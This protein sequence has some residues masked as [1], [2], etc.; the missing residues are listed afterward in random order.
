MHDEGATRGPGAPDGDA[1]YLGRFAVFAVHERG[2]LGD[3][4]RAHDLRHGRTVRLRHAP[5]PRDGEQAAQAGQLRERLA[6]EWRVAGIFAG[7]HPQ[8]VQVY[9]LEVTPEG[10]Q[11]LVTEDVEGGTLRERLTEAGLPLAAAFTVAADVAAALAAAHARGVVHRNLKPANIYLTAAGRAK[12]AD[13]S[14]AQIG[15]D[16]PAGWTHPYT[17]LY[18]SPEQE[19][20]R[21][22][23]GPAS[24]QYALGLV[25]F[26]MLTGAK[27]KRIEP[28]RA[29]QLLEAFPGDV[30]YLVTRMLATEPIDRFRSLD[31]VAEEIATLRRVYTATPAPPAP[32]T[33]QAFPGVVANV[34][35]I[36]EPVPARPD[37]VSPPPF[38]PAT[39]APAPTGSDVG[40]TGAPAPAGVM[41]TPHPLSPPAPLP[42]RE[43][44]PGRV[45]DAGR[46]GEPLPDAAASPNLAGAAPTPPVAPAQSTPRPRTRR[47][48]LAAPQ[49]T[50]A[51]AFLGVVARDADVTARFLDPGD[52][53]LHWEAGFA[54]RLHGYDPHLRC[55]VNDR[56]RWTLTRV[57]VNGREIATQEGDAPAWHA[58]SD[59]AHTLALRVRGQRGTLHVNG[60]EAAT[61]DFG[62]LAGSAPVAASPGDW[63]VIAR[64]T[65]DDVSADT[66]ILYD[67]CLATPAE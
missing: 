6:H 12:V 43:P 2:P 45:G 42:A 55:T 47:G 11:V 5:P 40:R 56:G 10:T 18:A 17:P 31:A 29:G 8:I 58:G 19:A 41:S 23:V 61:F 60:A 15:G 36:G 4:L 16:Q 51:V 30:R 26:E 9:A 38:P 65:C 28:V 25:L 22:P 3:T 7:P 35:Q 46:V 62:S 34:A 57:G 21:G 27:H 67:R 66:S 1:P 49:G 53:T 44:V 39:S 50:F 13:F 48:V 64:C 59:G 54:F 20:S 52:A 37:P 24:D 33:P 32:A 63:A 14:L